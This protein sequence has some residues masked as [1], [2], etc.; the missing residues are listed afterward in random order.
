MKTQS[1]GSPLG[2]CSP[3]VKGFFDGAELAIQSTERLQMLSEAQFQTR[4]LWWARGDL[5]PH[6]LSNTGT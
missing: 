4:L 6:I 3:P 5:N 2:L 1:K